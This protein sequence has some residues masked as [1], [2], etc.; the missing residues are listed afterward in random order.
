[1]I[2]TDDEPPPPRRQNGQ[3]ADVIELPKAKPVKMTRDRSPKRSHTTEADADLA[4]HNLEAEQA[5]IASILIEGTFAPE[6]IGILTPS[7]FYRHAHGLLFRRLAELDAEG[8]P[9]DL[10][11]VKDRLAR[12][13][14]LETVGGPMY[15]SRITD[16]VPRTI[17]APHYARVVKE[18]A[19]RR[20]LI[21]TLHRGIRAARTKDDVAGV[22]AG[23]ADHVEHIRDRE[24]TATLGVDFS[25]I[26]SLPEFMARVSDDVT[27]MLIE[28][29]LPGDGLVCAHGQPRSLKT[30]AIE[31]QLVALAT[32]T[33]AFGCRPVI[34]EMPVW[35]ITNEDNE[36]H[37]KNRLRWLLAARGRT[38]DL[39]TLHLS[40]CKGVDLDQVDWQAR[41]LAA[42]LRFGFGVIAFDPLRSLSATVDK[43]PSDVQPF[44]RYCRQLS[45]E[46]KCTT[47]MAHHDT[48]PPSQGRDDRR[49][50]DRISGGGLISHVD[51]PIHFERIGELPAVTLMAPSGWKHIETPAPLKL[52]LTLQDGVA[53]LLAEQTT[54]EA[55]ETLVH[56]ERVLDYLRAH[57]Y[58]STSDIR[59]GLKGMRHELVK[60]TLEQLFERGHVDVSRGPLR[61]DG[62]PKW[63]KWFIPA[64][65]DPL[66]E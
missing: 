57:P 31:E 22:L 47:L 11:Q 15:L 9:T 64:K 51:A 4:P 63:E 1:M 39:S 66:P 62:K 61:A 55:S 33:P 35:Y 19:V 46:A 53:R 8:L 7:D 50:Q 40:V 13:G 2:P 28:G 44:A 59:N 25:F 58:A 32:G 48:K 26:E 36:R 23:V 49:R 56:H 24:L 34:G 45:M 5:V 60:L 54:T 27:P 52:T 14:E 43:G 10:L 30:W 18:H 20:E 38:A 16:G 17:N 37:V 65:L 6:A 41:V 42:A 12:H 29:V 3:P 21:E